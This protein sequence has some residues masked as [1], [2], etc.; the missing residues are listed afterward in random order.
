MKTSDWNDPRLRE[1]GAKFALDAYDLASELDTYGADA[2]VLLL[3]KAEQRRLAGERPT[4]ITLPTAFADALMA[5][6]LSLPRPDIGRPR[7]W[8]PA[9]VQ[10]SMDKGM[11]LRAAAKQ[12]AARTGK[13]R[14]DIE[15][16]FRLW[17]AKKSKTPPKKRTSR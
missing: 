11:S 10:A 12:E 7:G 6:L 1:I 16:A 15:R 14:E 9:A 4:H 2:S 5:L 8:S 17:R 3:P 13:P